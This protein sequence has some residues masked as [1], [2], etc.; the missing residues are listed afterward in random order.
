MD[1]AEFVVLQEIFPSETAKYADV[2][3]PGVSWAEKW[4]TFT[5]TE[6]RV[7]LIRPAIP[8]LG[9]GR[10]D[11]AI[12]ADLARRVLAREGRRP[13]GPQAAWEYDSAATIMDEIAQVTPIYGGVHHDRLEAGE[14]LHWPV[15]SADHPG[16]PILHVGKFSRGKGVFHV[17]DHLD[18]E[19]LPD[20]EYPLFLTTGRVL[21]HWHG[22]EMTRRA[23]GLLEIYP[24]SM[25]EISPEDAA[26]IGLNGK[27]MVRVVSRRGEM[28][29]RALV[30]NR[31]AEGLVFGNFHFPDEQNVNN[32]TIKAL[33]PVA[34]IPEYKVCA[35]RVEALDN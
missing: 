1:K 34:K 5:N 19:E 33:D 7:Q 17:C 30:T 25:V 8:A 29:A 23:K 6:R 2:L 31:V 27:K 14:Q 20:E 28:I 10:P 16:T 12:T 15:L 11:W 13:E 18:A 26:R 24:E 22:A 9:E 21:Y 35:V 3:L 32:L 4:G